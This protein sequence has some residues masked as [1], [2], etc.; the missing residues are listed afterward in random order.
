MPF[1]ADYGFVQNIQEVRPFCAIIGVRCSLAKEKRKYSLP[2]PRL[3]V[4]EARHQRRSRR[5]NGTKAIRADEIIETH[6][7]DL[8][9]MSPERRM[10]TVF[11]DH[12]SRNMTDD[13]AMD[14]NNNQMDS[15]YDSGRILELDTVPRQ[16]LK[17]SILSW[18]GQGREKRVCQLS[19]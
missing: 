1:S 5:H 4:Q 19:K 8:F 7:S 6:G 15:V 13:D 18:M 3:Y 2:T 12:N 14:V 17:R 9:G 16:S 11:D 10:Q